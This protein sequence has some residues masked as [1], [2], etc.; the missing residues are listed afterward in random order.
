MVEW[1]S[2]SGSIAVGFGGVGQRGLDGGHVMMDARRE[3]VLSGVVEVS[4][5][6]LARLMHGSLSSRKMEAA[7]S[8]SAFD[9][10]R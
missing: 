2:S 3:V 5:A 1:C 7:T 4:M 8:K 10:M 6:G 9:G